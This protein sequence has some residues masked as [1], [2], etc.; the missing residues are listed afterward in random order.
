MEGI[1]IIGA[2]QAGTQLALSLRELGY[3]SP[4]KLISD[5]AHA[6]YHRP[7]LS[8]AYMAGG[9]QE[10]ELPIR[11]RDF[12]RD[13]HIELL[14]GVAVTSID[15][16]VQ[17]VILSDGRK[18]AYEHLVLATGARNRKLPF[19]GAEPQNAHYLRTWD[20]AERLRS[21]L[22]S[23]DDV[24]IIGAGFIGLEFASIAAETGKRTTVVE[25][26][27]RVMGRAVSEQTSV[28]FTERHRSA[29][30]KVLCGTSIEEYIRNDAGE[31][32]GVRIGTETR[33]VD[34][35]IIG[36][37]VIPNSELAEE[38][39]LAVDGG[40]VVDSNL[41]TADPAI[42][43]IGDCA[44]HPRPDTVGLVRVESVQN[45]ADQARFL[46]RRISAD[47]EEYRDIP[48]FWS[49]QAGDKLQ[50]AGLA[51]ATDGSILIGDPASRKFSVARIRDG[52][53]VAVESIN[54]AGDHLASRRLL[55]DNLHITE[56][57]LQEPGFSF[58]AA[59]KAA[60]D[61]Q[62]PVLA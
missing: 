41:T 48:W 52:R 44:R 4:I 27:P 57:E 18:L 13:Q 49:H 12:Y 3:A 7:P 37:G 59:G 8:K 5:E 9:L 1:V 24:M 56:H 33:S 45:A 29:G 6:P 34:L 32:T 21:A 60:K 55:A 50:I 2:G 42:S 16:E 40:I 31:I 19:E 17:R 47:A 10:A 38:A 22:Q 62:L 35:L 11:S 43:A 58:R 30:T 51:Q 28:Y 14:T 20:D 26:A 54:S 23:A 46:A 25:M 39:G 15:R 36:I 53:L 61:R